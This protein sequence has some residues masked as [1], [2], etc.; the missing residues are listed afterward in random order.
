MHDVL[1]FIGAGVVF[2]VCICLLL[3]IKGL[4]SSVGSLLRGRFFDSFTWLYGYIF[5]FPHLIAGFLYKFFRVPILLSRVLFFF[6]AVPVRYFGD[7]IEPYNSF[8][9][10]A[11]RICWYIVFLSPLLLNNTL[12]KKA[13][14]D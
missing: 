7:C 3:T 12:V 10:V 5:W 6:L 14:P 4:F 13:F 9:Y 2:V 11:A 8:L 1:F